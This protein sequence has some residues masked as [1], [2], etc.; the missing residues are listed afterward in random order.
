MFRIITDLCSSDRVMSL[1][2][3]NRTG[4]LQVELVAEVPGSSPAVM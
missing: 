3:P 2:Q 4:R 1:D